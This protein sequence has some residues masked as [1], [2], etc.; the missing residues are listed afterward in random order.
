MASLKIKKLWCHPRLR[1]V[2]LHVFPPRKKVD[3]L[4]FCS[5]HSVVLDSAYYELTMRHYDYARLE[6]DRIPLKKIYLA[7]NRWSDRH[8]RLDE[9]FP[10]RLF[11]GE[12]SYEQY[13]REYGHTDN[14]VNFGKGGRTEAGFAEFRR[15]IDEDGFDERRVLVVAK[16]NRLLD[17]MHRG[18]YLAYKY[19]MDYKVPVLRVYRMPGQKG[20]RQ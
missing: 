18:A 12:I 10:F 15:S 14:V 5:K 19:G 9:T 3:V 17:G 11:S 4:E 7:M 1:N 6:L 8:L 20:R 13:H 2:L 16:N